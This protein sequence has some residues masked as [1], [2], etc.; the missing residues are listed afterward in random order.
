MVLP[1]IGG[2]G[3]LARRVLARVVDARRRDRLHAVARVDVGP[4]RRRRR[5]RRR[6]VGG[7]DDAR[8]ERDALSTAIGLRPTTQP[9][10]QPTN[11]LEIVAFWLDAKF[12]RACA[13]REQGKYTYKDAMRFMGHEA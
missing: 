5:G 12:S 7:A 4:G 2:V 11:P 10:A 6:G 1:R 9:N 3:V 8:R 13:E